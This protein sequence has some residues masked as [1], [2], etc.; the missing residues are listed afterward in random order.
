MARKRSLTRDYSFRDDID[1]SVEF[2]YKPHNIT[3]LMVFIGALVYVALF[4]LKDD[5]IFNAKM[6]Y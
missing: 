1:P 6:Y 5:H 4:V 2:L 3:A